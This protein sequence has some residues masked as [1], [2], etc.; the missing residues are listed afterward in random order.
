MNRSYPLEIAL[1]IFVGLLVWFADTKITF[2]QTA[3][4]NTNSSNASPKKES[5]PHSKVRELYVPFDDLQVVLNE[6]TQRVYMTR[7]ELDDLREKAKHKSENQ[8]QHGAIVLAANYHAVIE[9]GRAT[10]VGELEVESLGDGLESVLLNLQHVSVRSAQLDGKP[11]MLSQVPEGALL[12]LEG[13]GIHHLQL[14]MVL[15]VTVA[16]AQQSLSYRVPVPPSSRFELKVPGNVE[17][18][19]GSAIVDRRVDAENGT[20]IFDLLPVDA[21]VSLSMSL[22]NRRLRDE[23]AV[24]ARGVFLDEITQ[25]YERLHASV[26]MNILHGATDEFR[27]L[28]PDN[29]DIT[30]V[31]TPLLARWSVEAPST[32]EKANA[33]E[34]ETQTAS[35]G[36][37]GKV[38]VVKLRELT[39]ER[40]VLNIRADRTS[41]RLDDW[42]MP[43]LTPLDVAGFSGVLGILLEDRLNSQVISQERLIPIDNKVLSDALPESLMTAEPGM[44]KI[45]PIATY[46]APLSDFKLSTSYIKRPAGLSV[47]TSL[48]LTLTDQFHR[49][50]GG[51]AVKPEAEK[52]FAFEFTTPDGWAID[53]VSASGTALPFDRYRSGTGWRVRASLPSGIDVGQTVNILFQATHSP[54]NWLSPW[55][56]QSIELPKFQSVGDQTIQESGAIAVRALDDMKVRPLSMNG[57]IVISDKEK[58]Q[59]GCGDV[60][61]NLAWRYLN[62]TWQGS[63]EVTR[64]EPRVTGRVL[65]FAQIG[66]ESVKNHVELIYDVEQARTQTLAFSLPENTPS[67]IAIHGLDDVQ[68]KESNSRVANGRRIWT[69]QLAEKRMGRIRLAVDFNEP[70]KLGDLQNYVLRDV[71]PENVIYYSGLIA[72]EGHAEL[73]IVVAEHSRAVDLGELVDAD[74][75]VGTRLLGV[76]GFVGNNPGVTIRALRHDVHA[77]PSTIVERA[78][79]ISLVANNGIAQT[80][81]RFA[82]RTK[83]AYLEVRLPDDATLWSVMVDKRP[84]LPESRNGSIVIALPTAPSQQLRDL[85]IVYEHPVDRMALRGQ[86]DLMAPLLWQRD[87]LSSTNEPI[88][89]ADLKWE[90]VLPSGYRL[91]NVGGNVSP[92]TPLVPSTGWKS[93]SKW[94]ANLGGG[95][96]TPTDRWAYRTAESAG[97]VAASVEDYALTWD[98][99]MT[100]AKPAA[101]PTSA[102]ESS[103]ASMLSDAIAPQDRPAEASGAVPNTSPGSSNALLYRQNAPS[104]TLSAEKNLAQ[105]S[106]SWAMEGFKCLAIEIAPI[107][108]GKSITFTSLGV[109]PNLK[110]TLVHESRWQWLGVACGLIVFCVGLWRTGHTLRSRLRYAITILLV[111][112]ILP[113]LTG[114][115]I[116]L[117]PVIQAVT[118]GCVA[119][120]IVTIVSNL[121]RAC[122]ARVTRWRHRLSGTPI[123]AKAALLIAWLTFSPW[124][125]AASN[126]SAQT[127]PQVDAVRIPPGLMLPPAD[128]STNVPTLGNGSGIGSGSGKVLHS[129]EELAAWLAAVE[130]MPAV[131]IPRDAIVVP[132]NPSD[133]QLWIENPE[134]KLLIPYAMYTELWNAAYPDKR[135][136]IGKP[137]SDFAWAGSRYEATLGNNEDFL[138]IKGTLQ[139]DVLVDREVAI[140]LPIA[141]GVLEKATVDGA[142]ARLHVLSPNQNPMFN[143]QRCCLSKSTYQVPIYEFPRRARE[144][145]TRC[146]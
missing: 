102:A 96:S 91:V 42:N 122:A 111:I 39:T 97:P 12:F 19:S 27:F 104:Q 132:Y 103:P 67:E 116:E 115:E 89:L 21:P 69:V 36:T 37:S 74:Y 1:M 31:R 108:L 60:P 110:A 41:N 17:L 53:S 95:I 76:Y 78:E 98:G 99:A 129:A 84:A 55:T 71:H 6:R 113:T 3:A 119:L 86:L 8:W 35:Q 54:N 88:P 145:C 25:G 127:P 120:L 93:W 56:E 92:E 65:L 130:K 68:V 126:S 138:K 85:Q 32:N 131:E 40:T 38:L 63:I 80:A 136:E 142:N 22:N 90:L 109:D 75:Q 49:V 20:T 125:F 15:P 45:R 4:T 18:K 70:V 11:A 124:F 83:A 144:L 114:W 87:D 100:G 72:V 7:K 143:S 16:A 94:L 139:V 14:E 135:L 44:P 101:P 24:V 123:T 118:T 134:Q 133:S 26:S 47:T 64:L 34:T 43:H 82:F 48:L 28:V 140:T 137:A 141:G 79:L 57:L 51:F 59:Y 23:S 112:L 46:Y 107:R 81:S 105:R 62:S 5:G 128:S 58:S 9:S 77:L 50:Q 61:T 73:N 2:A 30:D 10:I 121:M 117:E 29:F 106:Q 13:K 52:L 66:P 146:I 33:K